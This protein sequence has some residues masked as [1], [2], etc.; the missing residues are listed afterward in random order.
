MTIT[1]YHAIRA[2]QNWKAWG[3]HMAK[4]YAY[5]RGVSPSLLRLV[6]Q[7]EASKGI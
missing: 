2:A 4:A 5:K 6:R 1:T 7:L 3:A